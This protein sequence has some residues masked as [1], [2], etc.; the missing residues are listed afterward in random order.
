[1][2]TL[3]K[4]S[5]TRSGILLLAAALHCSPTR[6]TTGKPIEMTP[7]LASDLGLLRQA[8]I[9]FYHHSVGE[10]VLAGMQE[11]D[12]QAGGGPLRTATFAEAAALEGPVLAH[13]E[14]GQNKVPR[15]KVDFFAA[16]LRGHPGL[17]PDVAFMKFCYV[18]FQ[19]RTDVDELFAYY[20]RTIEA[21]KREHPRV[22]FAHDTVPLTDRPDDLKARMQRLLGREVWADAS[23]ARRGE[24]NR[25]LREG[26][27]SDPIF[28]LALTEATAPDGSTSSFEHG[29]RTY[30]S[31]QPGYTDDGGHLNRVGQR[32]AGTAAVH[33]I[34]DALRRGREP[35]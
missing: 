34:A 13:G 7:Q 16:T 4:A 1:M 3:P 27:P 12:S 20:Q 30:L 31:L 14:G 11:L 33:F 23:N 21:L 10:N 28:D 18:D 24:F 19:P 22:R 26:F 6:P 2:P 15:S 25:K 35:R 32:V 8:R 5:A 29:G 9:L 17:K